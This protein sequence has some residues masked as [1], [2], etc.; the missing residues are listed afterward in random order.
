[1]LSFAQIAARLVAEGHVR[2]MS[3]EGL[4]K[5]ART[6]EEWPLSD[7]DY[8]VVG[9]ARTAPYEVVETYI[10]TRSKRRGRG[11]AKPKA[12]ETPAPQPR[13]DEPPPTDPPCNSVE[14]NE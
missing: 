8:G 5:L 2:S 13:S 6:D 12:T 14:S 9:K 3:P 10:L 1:M 7:E 11:P 4:R